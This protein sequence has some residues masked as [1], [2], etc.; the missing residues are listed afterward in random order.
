MAQTPIPIAVRFPLYGEWCAINTPGH[1]VPSH[2]TDALGQ[3][4]AYDFFQI[5]WSEKGYVFFKRS[6]IFSLI[7]GVPLKNTYC[8]SQPIYS[9]FDGEVIESRDGIKERDPVHF[10]RDLAIVLK[11]GLFFQGKSN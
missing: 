4:F 9:P 6:N 1:K 10:I 11:N 2:G 8:W 3:T 5:D 7:F